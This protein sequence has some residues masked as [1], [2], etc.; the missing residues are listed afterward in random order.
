MK[1]IMQHRTELIKIMAETKCP[2]VRNDISKQVL[3]L[4]QNFNR[5][6]F[7]IKTLKSVDNLWSGHLDY[8]EERN[9][10]SPVGRVWERVRDCLDI[11]HIYK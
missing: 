2:H 4:D 8:E 5:T 11:I 9:N 1:E 7:F 10:N 6:D 3:S